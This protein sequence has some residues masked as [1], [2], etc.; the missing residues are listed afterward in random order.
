MA[1]LEYIVAYVKTRTD[2]IKKFD[3]THLIPKSRVDRYHFKF[4]EHEDE[5]VWPWVLGV[6]LTWPWRREGLG[7]GIGL[8][9]TDLW[10]G[11]PRYDGELHFAGCGH[12]GFTEATD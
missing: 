6:E 9:R 10:F 8:G 7:I 4:Q 3:W 2:K 5:L 11:W 1:G 12:P